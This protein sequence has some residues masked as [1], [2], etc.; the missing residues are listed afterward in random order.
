[1]EFKNGHWINSK[2]S[3]MGIDVKVLL[4]KVPL[5]KITGH[6]TSTFQKYRLENKLLQE[7]GQKMKFVTTIVWKYTTIY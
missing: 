6:A 1:M 3:H 2:Y 7:L 5:S 4:S